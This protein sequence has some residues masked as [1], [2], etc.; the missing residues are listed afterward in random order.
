MTPAAYDPQGF[1]DR[2]R[3]LIAVSWELAGMGW[4]PATSGNFSLRLDDRHIAITVSGR[5]KSHLCDED[6]IVVDLEGRPVATALCPSAETAL[7]AQLYRRFAGVGCVLHT[8]SVAQTVAARLWAPARR[9][10]LQ[11]YELQKAFAGVTAH[12]TVVDVPVVPNDQD[13][14]VLAGELSPLLDGERIFGYLI[15]GHGL[16]TWGRDL[17]EARRHLEALDF[18]I[19]CELEL[20]RPSP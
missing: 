13:M 11:G 10:R 6:I 7:H 18:L 5:D 4:T 15:A 3:Q 14:R 12:H 8:H 20:R 1:A 9:L 16:Y 17:S 19:R 2:R